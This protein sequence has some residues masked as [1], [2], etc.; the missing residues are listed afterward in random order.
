MYIDQ[1]IHVSSTLILSLIIY[2]IILSFLIVDLRSYQEATV[3]PI[4]TC[5]LS[6][7]TC[8]HNNCVTTLFIL[9]FFSQSE[10]QV[11]KASELY[12]HQ[13]RETL[14]FCACEMIG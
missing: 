7:N 10:T 2:I 9:L 11:L 13:E 12:R 4:D 5:N 3:Y 6:Y 14:M 1:T 8:R